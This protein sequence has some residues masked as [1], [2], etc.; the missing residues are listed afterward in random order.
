MAKLKKANITKNESYRLQTK[1]TLGFCCVLSAVRSRS[2]NQSALWANSRAKAG[3]KYRRWP[4][5]LS[6]IMPRLRVHL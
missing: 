1:M 6:G 3:S 2:Y 5:A 4:G